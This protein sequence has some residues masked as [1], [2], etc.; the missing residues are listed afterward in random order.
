MA[1]TVTAAYPYIHI[2]I[3][4][5]GLQPKASRAVGNVAVVGR[6]HAEG[7]AEVDKPYQISSEADARALFAKVEG[8]AVIDSS[9]LY[10]SL[11]L[12]LR[13][14]PAP[15]RVY[16]VRADESGGSANYTAALAKLDPLD[17]QFVVAAFEPDVAALGQLKSHVENAS[18]AGK[19]RL[20][21]AMVDPALTLTGT[22]T[23]PEEVEAVYAGLKSDSSRMVLVAARAD[24]TLNTEDVTLPDASVE[25]R[26][27]ATDRDPAAA[28]AGTIAGYNP[29]ISVLMKQVRGIQIDDANQFSP[30]EITQLSEQ[31]VMPVFD[32]ALI[33]GA[34]L[35]L[36]AGRTYTTDTS[37]LYV[38]IVR[39]LDDVEFRLKAGLIGAIGDVRIDRLGMQ[40]LR[41][42]IDS[43]LSP[44]KR[45]RVIANY[46]IY[47]PLLPILAKEEAS[48]TADESVQVTNSRIDRRVEAVLSIY[49]GP[50]V[51]VLSLE[52]ALKA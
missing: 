40:T 19:G 49:Y 45:R 11:Q 50:A 42:Q 26:R 10:D 41:S 7:T 37:R 17:V 4:T 18:A 46:D 28:V 31:F 47:L 13:Q 52:V 36:G 23:F 8:G 35:F 1:D 33:P 34:G 43:I 39:V 22:N 48:R 24:T 27:Y 21:V 15:S 16:A 38:D 6:G 2:R 14:D 12:A 5:R 3:D 51:H 44:L 32:P 30:S 20:G 25:T 29:H 9:D